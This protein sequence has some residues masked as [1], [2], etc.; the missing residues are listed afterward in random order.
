VPAILYPTEYPIDITKDPNDW[1]NKS[2]ATFFGRKAVL[3][4][5]D[6]GSK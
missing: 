5:P 6:Y 3:L 4:A 2:L 1:R